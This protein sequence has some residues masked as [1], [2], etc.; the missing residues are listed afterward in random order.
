MYFIT[1]PK[2][3]SNKKTER[4]NA[5]SAEKLKGEGNK[6]SKIMLAL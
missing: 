2:I 3:T 6:A 4:L 1:N 5:A